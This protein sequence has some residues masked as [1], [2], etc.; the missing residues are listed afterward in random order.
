MAPARALGIPDDYRRSRPLLLPQARQQSLTNPR[1][2]ELT[3]LLA[4]VSGCRGE[5]DFTDYPVRVS[6]T[7][8]DLVALGLMLTRS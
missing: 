6:G 2:D 8:G 4:C 7:C 5:Q 3:T 1:S